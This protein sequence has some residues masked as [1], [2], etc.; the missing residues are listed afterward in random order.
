MTEDK[1][2]RQ[3]NNVCDE[4]SVSRYVKQYNAFIK[5]RLTKDVQP[6]TMRKMLLL[7]SI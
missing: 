5:A 1:N 3:K 2:V 4:S 7:A 6:V